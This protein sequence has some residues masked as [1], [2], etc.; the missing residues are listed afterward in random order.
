MGS[1]GIQRAVIQPNPNDST[2]DSVVETNTQR[3]SLSPLMDAAVILMVGLLIFGLGYIIGRSILVS[4]LGNDSPL[5]I[6]NSEWFNQHLPQIPNW[7]PLHGGGVSLQRSYPLLPYLVV[8]ISSRLSGLTIPQ[9]YR[10]VGF[11]SV[12]LAALSVY[13]LG[14]RLLRSKTIGLVAAILYLLSPV[15]WSWIYREGYLATTLALPMLPLIILSFDRAV[16]SDISGSSYRIR[17]VWLASLAI[18][19]AVATLIHVVVSAA[20]ILGLVFYLTFS[21][22]V[23]RRGTRFKYF[24]TATRQL[25]VAGLIAGLVIAF[26]IIPMVSYSRVVGEHG[27]SGFSAGSIYQP[28]IAELFSVK[29]ID[30]GGWIWFRDSSIPLL[31]GVFALLGVG[32]SYFFSRRAFVVGLTGVAAIAY[33]QLP[34]IPTAIAGIWPMWPAIFRV[35]SVVILASVTLPVVAAYLWWGVLTGFPSTIQKMVFPKGRDG[36][37][38]YPVFS[39]ALGI[40][41]SALVL[42]IV[43]SAIYLTRSVSAGSESKINYGL[44]RAGFEANDIWRIGAEADSV[45]EQLQLSNWPAFEIAAT[46][47]SIQKTIEYAGH[48]PQE[49]PFR[50]DISPFLGQ[51]AQNIAFYS[52]GSQINTY[53]WNANLLSSLWGYQQAVSF[54]RSDE[55]VEVGDRVTLNEVAKWFGLEYALLNSEFDDADIYTDAGWINEYAD[56]ELEIWHYPEAPALAT[57]SSAPTILVISQND[58]GGYETLFRLATQ[59]AIPY[60]QGMLVRGE[61]RVDGY[62]IQELSRFDAVILYG[63]TYNNSDR[64]WELLDQYV[65]SGGSLFVDTGWQWHLPEWEFGEAPD[66]LPV[67]KTMWTDYGITSDFQVPSQS[68]IQGVDPSDFAPLEW[69]GAPWGVSGANL[70]DVRPWGNTILEV[71][72]H[73]VIVAGEYGEGRVV[74]SGMNFIS[75]AFEFDNQEEV[76]LL[77][78]LVAW[79]TGGGTASDQSVS[80]LRKYPDEILFDLLSLND[81]TGGLYW[82][83]SNHP[84]WHAYAV[85]TDGSRTEVPIYEAGPGFMFVLAQDLRPNGALELIW[86]TPVIDKMSGVISIVAVIGLLGFIADGVLM[87]GKMATR[88]GGSLRRS[89][90]A[91]E[92]APGVAWLEES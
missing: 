92:R 38:S 17:A 81:T 53:I 5:H 66:V 61:E 27:A 15:A 63:H 67:S 54:I 55:S 60:G 68:F 34:E 18:T 58:L 21:S 33:T 6:A 52:S 65:R 49:T 10:V 37:K 79:L 7:Y 20:A 26:W 40:G 90:T 16:L 14:W 62:D 59:G 75:H 89:K 30:A 64:A 2:V 47:P 28:E 44:T 46:D 85:G 41:R 42:A 25:V 4:T 8:A 82:R 23:S 88:L 83:E 84:A 51:L 19:I 50:F 87:N 31:V 1:V 72:G 45:T 78:S 29:D 70:Q 69:N 9:A 76:L 74:W 57:V 3:I 48:L 11:V 13:V 71:S 43:F 80:I 24:A 77:R 86:K 39:A 73:P 22:I 56:N 35:R 32:I 91:P 36:N 12:P